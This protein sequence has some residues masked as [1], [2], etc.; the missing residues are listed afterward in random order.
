[1]QRR[2]DFDP[3]TWRAKCKCKHTHEEHDPTGMRRCRKG[4]ALFILRIS[5]LA[6]MPFLDACLDKKL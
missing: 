3:S 2:R 4:T 5:V 6:G 1:M